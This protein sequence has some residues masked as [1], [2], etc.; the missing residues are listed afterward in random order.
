MNITLESFMLEQSINTTAVMDIY[1]EQAQAEL[2]VA[3]ALLSANLKDI[4]YQEAMIS[5]GYVQEGELGDSVGSAVSSVRADGKKHY[6]KTALAAVKAF[7]KFLAT[8]VTALFQKASTDTTT[9]IVTA[10]QIEE[11]VSKEVGEEVEIKLPITKKEYESVLTILGVGDEDGGIAKVIDNSVDIINECIDAAINHQTNVKYNKKNE[12]IFKDGYSLKTFDKELK[13]TIDS[14]NKLAAIIEH[15]DLSALRKET[16]KSIRKKNN[17]A[18]TKKWKE[19][20]EAAKKTA[21]ANKPKTTMDSIDTDFVVLKKG[22]PSD[23][24]GIEE[25]RKLK[26]AYQSVLNKW[27]GTS[28]KKLAEATKTIDD[29]VKTHES[30]NGDTAVTSMMKYMQG[31][32]T[33]LTAAV[34]RIVGAINKSN[35]M[36]KKYL[37]EN[38]PANMPNTGKATFTTDENGKLVNSNREENKKFLKNNKGTTDV[39]KQQQV[40]NSNYMDDLNDF[41]KDYGS[42]F[43]KATNL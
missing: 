36:V 23:L 38:K 16:A 35:E 8:K 2:N 13:P 25:Y 3:L 24:I 4:A 33:S 30:S 41:S 39:E 5:E 12:V 18:L 26:G 19:E 17:K 31:L 9:V 43:G 29:I 7:F 20:Q 15:P 11:A 28:K 32:I 27:N 1:V 6:I 42:G 37:K 21:E 40:I 22:T 14:L 34:N 10:E